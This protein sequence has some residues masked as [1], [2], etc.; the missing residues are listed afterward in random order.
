MKTL[1]LLAVGVI[2][3][4]ILVSAQ[5]TLTDDDVIKLISLVKLTPASQLD[6][7]LPHLTF[8]RW[9]RLQV[10]RD[11]GIAWAVRTADGHGLPWVEADISAQGRP[12]IVI[13]IACGTSDGRTA[14]KPTFHSLQLVRADDYADWPRL[15]DLPA[16]LQRARDGAR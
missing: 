13:M 16:A 5:T 7:V 3:S 12:G 9:L 2:F 14:S 6:P 1:A 4:S 10:G 15:R 8:G 11:A